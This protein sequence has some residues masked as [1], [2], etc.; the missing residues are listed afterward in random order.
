MCGIAGFIER[1]GRADDAV[2]A[3]L[4][5]G[6]ADRG[7]DDAGF[8]V[9]VPASAGGRRVV[10]VHRRLAILDLSPAGHQ[11]MTDL[12]TGNWIVYNGEIYNHPEL[13]T[14]LRR[15]G[16]A[17]RSQSDT[18]VILK[19]YAREGIDALS[20]LRGMFSLALWDAAREEL[21]LAVDPVGIKPLYYGEGPDSAFVFAS[22]TR[23]LVASGLV[24]ATVDLQ[25]LEGFL[26]YGSVQAPRTILRGV[27]ALLPGAYLRV[28]IDGRID[29]PHRYW[30]PPFALARAPLVDGSAVVEELRGVLREV[31]RSHLISDV[32]VGAFLSGGIDSSAVVALM[33]EAAAGDIHTFSVTFDE[34]EYSEAAYSR[35]VA[36]RYSKKHTEICLSE[37]ELLDMLPA[38]LTAVDQPSVD[39][40]NVFVISRAVREAGITVVLSGQ[41]GDELFGGYSTFG[42]VI[43]ARRWAALVHLLPR[44]LRSALA[45]LATRGGP[46]SPAM[47]KAAQFFASDVSVFATYLIL[48][49]LYAPRVRRRLFPGGPTGCGEDGLP[50]DLSEELRGAVV[51]LDPLNAV[52]LL[53]LR[54]FLPN[55][56]L[57][58]GDV[59]SMAHALE[60]R[61]P[62]LDQRVVEL[63]ASVPGRQKAA[64][65][66]PKPLLLRAMGQ[67]IPRGVYERPKQGFT[68]PWERWLRGALRPLVEETLADR[69]TYERL[70]M[71]PA[72]VQAVWASFLGGDGAVTWS[73]VWA[74]VTLGQ[75][76]GR[77]RVGA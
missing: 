11:P 19:C 6:L 18:E 73:R 13:R 31:V 43:R 34:R 7:P 41:G 75:W 24:P 10:L 1:R 2:A 37:R 39:G 36:Q 26:A 40:P 57:R 60:V 23:A 76:A 47:D 53:E 69:V 58:D 21:L 48:R 17:F 52:S 67:Q 32:P 9:L 63:V 3:G 70:G 25:G 20:R 12:T 71:D 38:A 64:A 65:G 68:F 5:D 51:R 49:Q 72:A 15:Q 45:A 4:L 66:L 14:E 44:R 33:S 46:A 55:T 35:E 28:R 16:V 77:H 29:G 74:L 62:F 50:P 27:R 56:M 8:E 61:V 59:M 54:T 22:E 30:S 42:R